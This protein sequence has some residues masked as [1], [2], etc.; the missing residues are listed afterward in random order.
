[1]VEIA[2]GRLSLDAKVKEFIHRELAYRFVVVE[3][4]VTAFAVERAA[5]AGGLR[6]GKP[7]LNS[8]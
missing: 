6:A 4:A 1:M 5:K 8:A 2:S 7:L 3:D